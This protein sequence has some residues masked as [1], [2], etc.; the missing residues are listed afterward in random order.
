MDYY[1]LVL[2]EHLNHYGNLFGGNLLKWIDEFSYI[3]ANLEFP[4][5]QFL[6]IAL[7]NVIFRHAVSNGE[8]LKF[9][10]TCHHLGKTSVQYSVKV[11]G[12]RDDQQHDLILF[13][14]KITF[15]SVDHEGKKQPIQPN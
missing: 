4:G 3:T 1:K 13:E 5:H 10:V 15:V 7:D 9:S 6:T 11:F 2:P 8:I 12:T 14:T